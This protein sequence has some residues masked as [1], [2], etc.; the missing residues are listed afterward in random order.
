M[1]ESENVDSHS[2]AAADCSDSKDGLSEN[3]DQMLSPNLDVGKMLSEGKITHFS[4]K[5]YLVFVS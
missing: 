3:F 5:T 2:E 1:N 4:F